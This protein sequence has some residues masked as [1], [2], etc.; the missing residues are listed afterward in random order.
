V[1]GW[2][3][4]EEDDHDERDAQ[5][6]TEF[7]RREEEGQVG[8]CGRGEDAKQW[9]GWLALRKEDRKRYEICGERR[10]RSW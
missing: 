10:R 8:W 6:E 9:L 5:E 3:T 1:V 7:W 4:F 2:L